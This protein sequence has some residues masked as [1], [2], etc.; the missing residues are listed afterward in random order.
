ML[1]GTS[2]TDQKVTIQ[3]QNDKQ[4]KVHF[5]RLHLMLKALEQLQSRLPAAVWTSF[6]KAY[7]QHYLRAIEYRETPSAPKF[8][9]EEWAEAQKLG[10]MPMNSERE[11]LH[12]VRNYGQY[13]TPRDAYETP[14]GRARKTLGLAA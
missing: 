5:H 9:F 3:P 1:K 8:F 6:L 11:S 4:W 10:E 14:R 7:S 13:V 2:K 12:H